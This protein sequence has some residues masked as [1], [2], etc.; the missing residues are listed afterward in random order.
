MMMTKTEAVLSQ[1][2]DFVVL[3]PDVGPGGRYVLKDSG[4]SIVALWQFMVEGY[5]ND[6]IAAL[7]DGVTVDDVAKAHSF[8]DA[9]L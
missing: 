6:E 4:W 1:F 9:L 2:G 8:I 7:L 3:L 5:S